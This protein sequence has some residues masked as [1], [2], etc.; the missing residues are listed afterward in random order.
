MQIR[1][2]IKELRLPH[3]E[4]GERMNM[5]HSTI[6]LPRQTLEAFEDECRIRR[7]GPAM[8]RIGNRTLGKSVRALRR[9]LE[10]IEY[11][12]SRVALRPAKG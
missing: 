1:G 9:Q 11:R 6:E 8:V 5:A 10:W 2:R 12:L 3:S 7:G 4:A